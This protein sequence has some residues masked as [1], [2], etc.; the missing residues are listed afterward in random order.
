LPGRRVLVS[1]QGGGGTAFVPSYRQNFDALTVGNSP[2]FNAFD[3]TTVSNAQSYSA[4]NSTVT[5]IASGATAVGFAQCL[6]TSEQ[7]AEGNQVWFRI[8][9]FFPTGF[10]F[11]APG[12]QHLKFMRIDTGLPANSGHGSHIDW[13]I[14]NGGV[15]N[16]GD[17]DWI[18]E[19]QSTW[20][21]GGGGS[22]A[23]PTG[24]V[25]GQWQTWEVYY[26]LSSVASTAIIRLWRNGTLICDTSANLPSGVTQLSTINSGYIVGGNNSIAAGFMHVT[27]W[28]GG[29]PQT[30]SWYIDDVVI[31]TSL[32]AIPTQRDAA[33][34]PFLGLVAY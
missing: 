8:R 30:Q 10:N 1:P 5:T 32:N 11:Q 2:G 25:T 7:P 24:I 4:P 3:F 15:N 21:F 27:Y 19:G 9:T 23:L 6:S 18:Y 16:G 33:G 31:N 28:N 13:Y 14:F 29:A 12:G 17:F 26:R 34:N 22:T 20:M